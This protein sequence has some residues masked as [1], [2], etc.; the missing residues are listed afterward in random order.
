MRPP[1]LIRTSAFRLGLGTALAFAVSVVV[2]FGIVEWSA[3]GFMLHQID[4]TIDNELDE[5]RADAAS[6]GSDLV[7]VVS[8]LT[9]NSPGLAYS[10]SDADGRTLAG[11][12]APVAHVSGVQVLRSRSGRIRGHGVMLPSG[13]F[14]F[15]GMSDLEARAMREAIGRAFGVG[16]LV[17]LGFSTVGG[18]VGGLGILR[19]V[20]AI[21]RTSRDIMAGD[22]ARRI[23]LG[24]S[25]DEFDH[26][27]AS[28]NAMLD[29]IEALMAGLKQVSSDIAHDLRTPLSRLR[30]RLERAREIGTVDG[31][32]DALDGSM[33]EIDGILAT[34]GALLRIVQIESGSRRSGFTEVDLSSLL[35][36]LADS[37]VPVAEER[38]QTVARAVETGLVVF[39]DRELLTQLFVNLIENAIRHTPVGTRLSIE[40]RRA[41]GEVQAVVADSGLGIPMA[42]RGSVLTR[43]VRLDASRTTAG[44]GLGL[45]L[46]SAIAAL[47]EATLTL[48][49]NEP[50]LRCGV[51]LR[52]PAPS[53]HG[54]A[55]SRTVEL[56]ATASGRL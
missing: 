29:R 31:L 33:E 23:A 10:L 39:G 9:R 56:R 13:L 50:G 55:I 34:F 12:L 5:V 30:Q 41:A 15:V 3:S 47:H 28:L 38:S 40:A 2:L 43:F 54:R 48:E 22:L 17:V 27:A 14:L 37:Y 52:A 36:D 26:L 18:L 20:E 35:D 44:N 46:V 6:P 11:N 19:R 21:S 32:R 24:D 53:V 7:G 45:G 49:D 51:R 16:F 4:R 8:A 1:R 42:Y 25:D